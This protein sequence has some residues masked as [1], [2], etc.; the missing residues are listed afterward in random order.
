MRQQSA[1]LSLSAGEATVVFAPSH[2]RRYARRPL[3]KDAGPMRKKI[4]A[5]NWKMHGSRAMAA[6]LV[7]HIVAASPMGADIVL[8]PPN[9]Y[10]GEVV[11]LCQGSPIGVGAQDLAEQDGTGAFTGD[12]SADMLHDVGARWVLVG[13][14][15]RREYHAETNEMLAKKF[16]AAQKSGLTPILCIGET[17]AERDAGRCKQIVG[18]QLGAVIAANGIEAFERAV[19]AYEP[20]WAIGTGRSATAEQAQEVHA[21]IRSQLAKDDAKI[22]GLT[23]VLYGG[24]VKPANAAELFALPDVDGGL[25]GGASLAAADFLAICAAAR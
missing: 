18:E 7:S 23:R 16:A 10:I 8:C 13:H 24:S 21:F 20:V 17:L 11:R 9:V 5:G 12:V 25:I 1:Q 4:V 3:N 14:S 6:D 2:L 22:A 19:I 15:E